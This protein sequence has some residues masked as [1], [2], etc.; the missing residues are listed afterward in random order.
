LT[1]TE[2]GGRIRMSWLSCRLSGGFY[3]PNALA[4][5]SKNWKRCSLSQGP[6]QCPQDY[7]WARGIRRSLGLGSSDFVRSIPTN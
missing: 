4:G 5:G 1:I 7:S 6:P 3:R 2:E